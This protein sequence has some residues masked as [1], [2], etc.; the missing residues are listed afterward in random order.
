MRIGK[1]KKCKGELYAESI[2][3][4]TMLDT[5]CGSCG[6]VISLDKQE[7]TQKETTG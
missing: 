5:K 1:C 4:R 2:H 6:D 3:G 7:E